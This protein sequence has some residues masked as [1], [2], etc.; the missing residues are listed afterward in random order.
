MLVAV[1]IASCFAASAARAGQG[2]SGG[3]IAP[4]SSQASQVNSLQTV[5]D[6]MTLP[7]EG[8]PHG[9]PD[10]YDWVRGPSLGRGSHPPATWHAMTAWGQ[11]YEDAKGNPA[12][13]TR[14]QIRRMR[15][16]LLS[17]RDGQWHQVQSS[18]GVQGAAYREDFVEDI[19]KQ[20]DLRHESDGS[21]S[22]TA[23]GGFNFHFWPAEGRVN[24]DPSDVAGVF[25]TVEAR[26]VVDDPA[27]P[28]DRARARYLLSVGGDYWQSRQAKWDHFKT[29]DAV[30]LGRFKYVTVNWQAFNCATPT[31][32][33][34]R[35]N[36]PPL[37]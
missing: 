24:I 17:K 13:N 20:P 12:R 27:K 34:L 14:V 4:Q 21:V 37:E 3:K 29:N 11:L 25:I 1:S 5:I 15:T 33:E 26:L 35:Q 32:Q 7:H 8:R 18:E 16:Y 6:D 23:G 22:V 9:V 28:D 19:N 2:A 36:P 10:S 31:A 30:G